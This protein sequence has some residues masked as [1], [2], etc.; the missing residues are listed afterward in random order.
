MKSRK[1]C[2]G[3]KA[4]IGD[5]SK[6][7]AFRGLT[8][9]P[10]ILNRVVEADLISYI[11]RMSSRAFDKTKD[12]RYGRGACSLDF[13]LFEDTS[14]IIKTIVEDLTKIMMEAVKSD[15][16]IFDSFFNILC[17]GGGSTPHCHL[18]KLDKHIG[19]NLG[20]QKY[21][22]VYYLAV[23]DQNCSE[24][25]IL[26]LY[27]PVED[28]LPCDGMLTIIPASREHSAVYDGTT[29]RIMIGVNFYSLL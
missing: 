18:N 13:S 28:I 1:S 24:P 6:V 16:Y 9:N 26:K 7:N 2:E 3:S 12:A 27:D 20:K 21:S 19:L 10:L 8:S 5:A 14:S 25:G 22:L 23:G 4:V 17:A 15:I 29:D 11:Y